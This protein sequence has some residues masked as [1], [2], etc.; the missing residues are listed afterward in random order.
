MTTLL[1]VHDSLDRMKV[2]L[3]DVKTN[4]AMA[5][6]MTKRQVDWTRW[7]A[8]YAVGD[9]VLLSTKHLKTYAPHLPMKLER[10][11]VG[12]FTIT[13]EVS[14]VVFGLDLPPGWH[15]HPTFHVS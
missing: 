9:E 14:P 11:W 3:D 7:V 10:R 4:L 1:A 15:I 6:E 8:T 12:L 5:Q 13:R 2:A